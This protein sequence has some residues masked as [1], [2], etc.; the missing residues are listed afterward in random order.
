MAD[1]TG[2]C[3]KDVSSSWPGFAEFEIRFDADTGLVLVVGETM[4]ARMAR[5]TFSPTSGPS[6]A[7]FGAPIVLL[8][9]SDLAVPSDLASDGW[10]AVSITTPRISPDGSQLLLL[11]GYRKESPP[12][13]ETLRAFWTCD[14]TY[15]ANS[16]V[17]PIDPASCAEVYRARTDGNSASGSRATW[18]VID[19]TI[20]VT[21]PSSAD[22]GQHSLWRLS[23]PATNPPNVVEVFDGGGFE[24]ARAFATDDPAASNGELVAVYD[25]FESANNW[26]GRVYVVDAYEDCGSS[27]ACTV[28]NNQG[29]GSLLRSAT[30]LPDGRIAGQGNAPSRQ[31]PCT[32]TGTLN[33][34]PAV[35]P[36]GTPLTEL[37]TGDWIEGIGGG[38]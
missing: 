25:R 37:E 31:G 35:D 18:G 12:I 26:C 6:V 16:Q 33:A 19:G 13:T 27:H 7:P 1:A 15:D 5:V 2:R 9:N 4:T 34:F 29:Q 3:E 23:L 14:L 10:T 28:L 38:W 30:W 32:S 17:Q 11:R 24:Y 36:Y 21:Q 8:R 20:Y 22:T